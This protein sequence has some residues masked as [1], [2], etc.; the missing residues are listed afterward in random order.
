[1][2]LAYRLGEL[3]SRDIVQSKGNVSA[4]NEAETGLQVWNLLRGIS[5]ILAINMAFWYLGIFFGMAGTIRT[6]SMSLE[7][8]ASLHSTHSRE[9][10]HYCS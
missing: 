6:L 1:M 7:S 5:Q 4:V 10:S 9:A 8:D 2:Q 3:G